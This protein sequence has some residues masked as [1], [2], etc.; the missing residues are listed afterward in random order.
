MKLPNGL[1]SPVGMTRQ[2]ILEVLLREEYGVL[3][4]AP[5]TLE[6]EEVSRNKRSGYVSACGGDR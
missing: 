1:P 3:P 4:P 5:M 6:V 2:E